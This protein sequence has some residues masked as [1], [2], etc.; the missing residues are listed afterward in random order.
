LYSASFR[1]YCFI[2]VAVFAARNNFC[3]CVQ[4]QIHIEFNFSV[5][6]LILIFPYLA[7]STN[8]SLLS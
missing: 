4:V 8:A 2:A 7:L 6:K 5:F 3:I 1:Q